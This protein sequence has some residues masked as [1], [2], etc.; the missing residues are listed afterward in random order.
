MAQHYVSVRGSGLRYRTE[1]DGLRAVAVIPVI[2]FHAGFKEFTG[3]FVGVDVF[4]VISGYLITSLILAEV[5]EGKFSLLNFYE[6]RARRILPAL[7]FVV[8]LAI[9]AAWFLLP[10]NELKEFAQSLMAVAT[11][12]SNILF[13]RDS[14]YFDMAAE[15]KPLLHTWSLAI[16]EQ[17]YILFPLFLLAA[18]RRGKR[19]IVMVLIAAFSFS[20]AAAQLGSHVAPTAAFYVLPTRAW[21]LLMGALTAFY[22]HKNSVTTPE[23]LNNALSG[24]GFLA[25]LYAVYAF[26]ESTPFPSVYALVPTVGTALIILFAL[27]GTVIHSFLSLRLL[28][29]VGLISYSLYLWHQ[30]IFVFFRYASQQWAIGPWPRFALPLV[31]ILAMLTWRFIEQPLRKA[32][33]KN[34]ISRKAVLQGAISVPALVFAVGFLGATNQS[35][36]ESRFTEHQLAVLKQKEFDAT[37]YAV[38]G[39]DEVS[40]Q[41]IILGDSH[42]ES[43]LKALGENLSFRG[44]SG[45]VLTMAGC[46]PALNLWRHDRQYGAKCH[47]HYSEV[48]EA[49]RKENTIKNVIIS[50]RYAL[51]LNSKR[52]DNGLSGIEPGRDVVYDL[53]EFRHENRPLELRRGAVKGELSD[54]IRRLLALNVKVFV[55][56]DIPEIGWDVPLRA[57]ANLKGADEIKVPLS[58][59]KS[60]SRSSG[61]LFGEFEGIEQFFLFRPADVFCDEIDCYATENGMPLYRDTNHPNEAGA[62]KLV[63]AFFRR[64]LEGM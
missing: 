38:I 23:W 46:P 28:V 5:D 55:I 14:G 47:K 56:G 33:H 34:N 53:Y 40:P 4:F 50:A 62:E 22:L 37:P 42:A 12:S 64:F 7:F 32:P 45:L 17:F 41:W 30:P 63:I 44:E 3:G 25:I 31:V 29:G 36:N 16:E 19:V 52:F 27:P 20:L 1:I 24:I 35:L 13:W 49:L 60:R 39:R 43:L 21:E 58:R 51:Y 10:P 54:Y 26:S 18:W 59:Y 9:P 6:R 48:L 57:L 8:A 2:F 11:F 15:L 61:Q